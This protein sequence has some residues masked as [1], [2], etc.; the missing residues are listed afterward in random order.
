MFFV[1]ELV[2][3]SQLFISHNLEI[4]CCCW[5][6]PS[7]RVMSTRTLP[8]CGIHHHG[9]SSSSSKSVWWRIIQLVFQLTVQFSQ[10]YMWNDMHVTL[11][12]AS[13]SQGSCFV[14]PIAQKKKIP[15]KMIYDSKNYQILTQ[16]KLQQE[17]NWHFPTVFPWKTIATSNW[18]SK[19]L[20][21]I[22]SDDRLID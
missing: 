9:I 22:L 16:E 12:R 17:N 2:N 19:L 15:L 20:Q 8:T 1:N 21:I 10:W 5:K 4:A 11:H 6:L 14:W 3:I 7:N 18:L 13:N